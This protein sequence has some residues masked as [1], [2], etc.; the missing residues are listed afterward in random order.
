MKSDV[1]KK[2]QLRVWIARDEAGGIHETL[3][4]FD[5]HFI[6]ITDKYEGPFGMYVVDFMEGGQV[7]TE[8]PTDHMEH[9]SLLVS[10]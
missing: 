9:W 6:V 5:S 2:G 7:F 4:G 8:Q 3:E 10:D 1:I